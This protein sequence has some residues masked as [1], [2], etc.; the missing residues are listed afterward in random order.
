M[1]VSTARHLAFRLRSFPVASAFSWLICGAAGVLFLVALWLFFRNGFA[2]NLNSDAAV[3]VLL[4]AESSLKL[5]PLPDTW[6][7]V[8]DDLWILS[9]QLFAF[10]FVILLGAS[11]TALM[12]GN[13]LGLLCIV[14]AMSLL[15]H[16][17]SGSWSIAVTLALGATAMFSSLQRDVVYVQIAY[18]W[19]SAKVALLAYLVL[20]MSTC[21]SVRSGNGVR[22][23]VVA[24]VMLLALLAAENP[25]RALAFWCV[26]MA[27]VCFM[28]EPEVLSRR[29]AV[30]LLIVSAIAAGSGAFLHV[31][32]KMH[33]LDVIGLN[34]F[35][36]RPMSEWAGNLDVLWR[37]LPY[38]IGYELV[39]PVSPGMP[40]AAVALIRT[41]F[42]TA[43]AI[44]MAMAWR[45]SPDMRPEQILFQ[46][47]ACVLLAVTLVL[48]AIGNLAI[49]APS[50]RYLVPAGLL[51][52]IAFMT[53]VQ[54]GLRTDLLRSMAVMA[55]F[56]L[57]FC[58]GGALAAIHS[59]T[60][61]STA[62][63][64]GPTRSCRLIAKL[65]QEHLSR[66]F[67]SYWNANV[68]TLSSGGS[69]RVCGAA[70]LPP[71]RPAR[72]LVSRDC[73]DPARY[74][75]SYFY[76]FTKAEAQSLD[77][78][79]FEAEAGAPSDVLKT[80]DYEIWVYRP[81]VDQH[82]LDWLSR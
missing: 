66:G 60:P 51:S 32:L 10:P 38:L 2:S 48:F 27:V 67:A 14:G 5:S 71:L 37:G 6:Y 41:G 79:R 8:N 77:R 68:T 75:E 34:A 13:L 63:C 50:V 43:T 64:F 82:R 80:D 19:I 57:A 15:A 39:G 12:L 16:R 70:L 62:G 18:G 36:V 52:L 44:G 59:A 40:E 20:R 53:R 74:A 78:A 21:D 47:I 24:Y 58:G 56:V 7:Y 31:L 81:S 22:W 25:S 54:Q 26:P 35:V 42:F 23:E 61:V 76:A 1:H 29:R 33:L 17:L 28:H 11:S 72:W 55:A 46:R 45:R 69:V 9:P 4:A 30:V 65:Q 49:A 3:P 73:F